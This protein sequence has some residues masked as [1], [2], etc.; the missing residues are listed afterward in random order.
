MAHKSHLGGEPDGVDFDCVWVQRVYAIPGV[1]LIDLHREALGGS[2]QCS[3]GL[4]SKI[5]LR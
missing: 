1:P 4:E 5:R 2:K 3:L